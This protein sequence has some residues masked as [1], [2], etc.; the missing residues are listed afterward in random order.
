ML[1]T[2]VL[3]DEPRP[4]TEKALSSGYPL[5]RSVDAKKIQ[6]NAA[7]LPL[8]SIYSMKADASELYAEKYPRTDAIEGRF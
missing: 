7:I 2:L 5:W 8:K 1:A 6:G 4:W 3:A